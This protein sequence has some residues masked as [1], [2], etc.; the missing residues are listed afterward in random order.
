MLPQEVKVGQ[1]LLRHPLIIHKNATI[2]GNFYMKLNFM[3]ETEL[4]QPN[5]N[6]NTHSVT[7]SVAAATSATEITTTLVSFK[8]PFSVYTTGQT[9]PLKR[10]HWKPHHVT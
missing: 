6:M 5:V 4:N 2:Y 1:H 9:V 10:T 7:S 8:W 3:F